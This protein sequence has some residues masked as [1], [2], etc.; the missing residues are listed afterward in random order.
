VVVG[1]FPRFEAG[2]LP[3][4]LAAAAAAADGREKKK[5]KEDKGGGTRNLLSLPGD[6]EDNDGWGNGNNEG[7][8]AEPILRVSYVTH[9]FNFWR[10]YFRF[11]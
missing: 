3:C 1:T 6:N 2:P 10:P 4:R 9:I 7:V 11:Y 8:T 5:K